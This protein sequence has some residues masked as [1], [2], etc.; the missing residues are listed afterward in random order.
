MAL[1]LPGIWIM[2][3]YKKGD[4]FESTE[5]LIA[6]GCNCKG[7]F[8]SG[9]A[10]MMAEKYPAARSSYMYKHRNEGWKL[11]D[12]DFA[13]QN[14]KIIA[15]C[16]TQ[17]NFLPRDKCHADYNAIR[18]CMT[19]VLEYAKLRNLTI[20]IPKIGAGLAG[21]DWNLIETILEDVFKDYDISVYYLE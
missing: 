7:G 5:D 15:N 8:A 17:D 2:V 1:S 6:H 9:V 18:V 11:G 20:A 3:I 14:R 19:K 13:H 10:G 12:V 4:L 21:G 16:A